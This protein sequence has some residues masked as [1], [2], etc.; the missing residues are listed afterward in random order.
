MELLADQSEVGGGQSSTDISRRSQSNNHLYFSHTL[1]KETLNARILLENRTSN[2][3]QKTNNK[4]I[5][6]SLSITSGILR[7]YAGMRFLP[8]PASFY[9]A[10]Y[11]FYSGF[12]DLPHGRSANT[13]FLQIFPKYFLPG[14]FIKEGNKKAGMFLS[15]SQDRFL[16]SYHPN[17]NTG[18]LALNLKRKPLPF[19]LY[20]DVKKISTTAEGYLSARRDEESDNFCLTLEG[21]RIEKW[22]LVNTNQDD[23]SRKG[24]SGLAGIKSE[25][26]LTRY[27]RIGIN[28]AGQDIGNN[29]YRTAEI[30]LKPYQSFSFGRPIVRKRAYRRQSYGEGGSM[31]KINDAISLGWMAG[32]KS[33]FSILAEKRNTGVTSGEL[34][35]HIKTGTLHFSVTGI[36]APHIIHKSSDFL[37]VRKSDIR[38]DGA[39]FYEGNGM[40]FLTLKNEY[41]YFSISTY[42]REKKSNILSNFQV[43][44]KF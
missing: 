39:T 21:E 11:R 35:I 7:I 24:K 15:D 5:Y 31:G 22:D 6:P 16:I 26:F 34:Q 4:K 2:Y 12:H 14:I 10:D 19:A 42:Q 20:A 43:R 18:N 27:A 30:E 38:G 17:T 29:G 32:K 36:F 28:G 9:L 33:G 23:D 37:F 1:T 8:G 25:Y 3:D 13:A 44:I 41:I 40:L